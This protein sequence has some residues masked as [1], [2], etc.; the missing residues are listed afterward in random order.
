M[1]GRDHPFGTIDVDVAQR[2]SDL[3][4]GEDGPLDVLNI[5]TYHGG[6]TTIGQWT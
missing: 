3:S 6:D 4:R 5:M 2:P 1:A